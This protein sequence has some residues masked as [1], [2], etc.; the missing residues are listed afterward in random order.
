MP[1]DE[2]KIVDL[3]LVLFHETAKAYLVGETEK[4]R[5]KNIWL[6]KAHCELGDHKGTVANGRLPVYEFQIEEWLA[7]DKELI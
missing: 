3:T 1:R 5:D 7:L 2:P 4:D 6:P